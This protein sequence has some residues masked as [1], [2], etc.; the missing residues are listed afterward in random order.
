MRQAD[1]MTDHPASYIR[2]G[3]S[4]LGI[5][6]HALKVEGYSPRLFGNFVAVAET[7]VGTLRIIYDREFYV[8][9]R[10]PLPAHLSEHGI[11]AALDQ[12]MRAESDG[13]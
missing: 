7:D 3:L 5:Q 2:A 10:Q 4:S 11:V 12:A 1:Q 9:V 8:D 6:C 13:S